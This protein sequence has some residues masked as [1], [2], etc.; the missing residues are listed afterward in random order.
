MDKNRG[1][2]SKMTLVIGVCGFVAGVFLIFSGETF[3]GIAGSVASAGLALKAYK[4]SK[5]S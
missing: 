3:I 5:S 1:N 2:T 4:N